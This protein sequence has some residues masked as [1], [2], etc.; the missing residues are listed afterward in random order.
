MHVRS[1]CG[2]KLWATLPGLPE[3]QITPGKSFG[4]R[5]EDPN[6]CRIPGPPASPACCGR[7]FPACRPRASWPQAPSRRPFRRGSAPGA[8]VPYSVPAVFFHPCSGAGG[9][10][11]VVYSQSSVWERANSI[12]RPHGP[13][14]LASASTGARGQAQGTRLSLSQDLLRLLPVHI[15][16]VLDPADL[17]RALCQGG[18]IPTGNVFDGKLPA[19]GHELPQSLRQ[20]LVIRVKA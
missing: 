19:A 16:D 20:P 2:C 4:C 13:A 17:G 11:Q 9:G 18:D 6:P 15:H 12:P 10:V 1:N 5:T 3:K 14:A 8:S 7:C